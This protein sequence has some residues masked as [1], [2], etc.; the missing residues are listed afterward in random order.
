[1]GYKFIEHTADVKVEVNE[2]NL[3][4]AF[5]SS[6]YALKELITNKT[7]IKSN[8]NKKIIIKAKDY[9][10]LLYD[11]LEEFL[12]L[13]DAKN[14]IISKIIKFNLS[15]VKD[16]F[17]IKADL[18]GDKSKNYKFNNDVKAITY[19]DMLIK[20]SKTNIKL[21]FVVDV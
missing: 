7:K 10:R 16:N 13:L 4:K 8:I 2:K 21:Q 5:C 20:Q 19:N 1:M 12:Y 17:V 18:I 6:A 9:S 15:K 14:F 11:F 3:E